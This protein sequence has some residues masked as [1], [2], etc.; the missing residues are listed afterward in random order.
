MNISKPK[1]TNHLFV[2]ASSLKRIRP[3]LAKKIDQAVILAADPTKIKPHYG[4]TVNT[5]RCPD[6]QFRGHSCKHRIAVWL[7]KQIKE[8][9]KIG[10]TKS[11]I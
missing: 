11:D 2:E 4:T 9:M 10:K 5:C 8:R 3:T 1:V 6:S 7:L